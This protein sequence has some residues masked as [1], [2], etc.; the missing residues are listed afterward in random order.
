MVTT[1][2]LSRLTAVRLQERSVAPDAVLRHAGLPPGLFL[3]E[4]CLLTTEQLFAF[5]RAV[6]EVSGDPGDRAGARER[7]PH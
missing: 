4:K 2:R 5:W 6:G 1:F 3:E 7:G